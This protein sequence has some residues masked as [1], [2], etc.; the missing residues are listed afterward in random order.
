[1]SNRE[2]NINSPSIAVDRF[3]SLHFARWVGFLVLCFALWEFDK[4]VLAIFLAVVILFP[5]RRKTEAPSEGQRQLRARV[6]YGRSCR[7]A[8]GYLSATS[9]STSIG[10]RTP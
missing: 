8:F 10:C 5:P 6:G 2:S 4:S 3:S 9:S 7:T 1:M